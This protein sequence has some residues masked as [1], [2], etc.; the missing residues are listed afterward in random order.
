MLYFYTSMGIL[1]NLKQMFSSDIIPDES[2]MTG[3]VY[4]YPLKNNCIKINS[5]L[6]VPKGF[7]FVVGYNGKALDSFG[8]GDFKLT[9]STL[10]ECCKKLKI[11]K[12]TKKGNNKKQ[13]KA[14]AY[15]IKLSD[16]VF[17]FKTQEKAELGRKASGIFKV[18]LSAKIKIKIVD[19]KK[20]LSCMLSEFSYIKQNEAE[21]ILC[22]LTSDYVINI[23][24]KYNF[25][26]SEFITSNNI[27]V[28]N[29]SCELA[30][31]YNKLGIMLLDFYEVRYILP[32]K[33]MSEYESNL[34]NLTINE[35]DIQEKSNESDKSSNIENQTDDI[36]ANY[37]PYGNIKI[38]KYQTNFDNTLT[39]QEI[40][41]NN[42]VDEDKLQQINQEKNNEIK[43]DE[44][45]QE[46]IDLN[47]DNLYNEK[48]KVGKQCKYCGLVNSNDA[49]VCEICSNKL[50]GENE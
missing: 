25:A 15:F 35:D 7:S 42:I 21:K 20:F 11:N 39:N 10:P 17:N 31:K 2:K 1:S 6:F 40:C 50:G 12:S 28:E 18:G 14:N 29:I 8:E 45:K 27:I 5:K 48:E 22:Y 46:F 13:F 9:F 4:P 19:S 43:N 30:Q 23:L 37:V 36:L 32:K 38:E 26:L 24:N 3:I 16:Y 49:E 41:K 33:Y 47:L 34:Q 44:N